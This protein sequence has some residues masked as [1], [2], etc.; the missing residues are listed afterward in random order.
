M[1]ITNNLQAA[2]TQKKYQITNN[3]VAKSQKKLASGLKINQAGDDA[4]G[5]AISEKMRSQIIA[6]N[7]GSQN[8]QDGISLVQTAEG[9]LSQ[10]QSALHRMRELAVQSASDTNTPEARAALNAEFRQLAAEVGD[11]AA[12]TT[13]NSSGV[14]DGTF[15]AATGT[16]L[17][18]QA[19]ANQGDDVAV[20]IEA[21]DSQALGIDS[22]SIA[23]GDD[24]RA[25]ITALDSAIN[26]VSSQ[27]ADLGAT[28]NR[29]E[30]KMSNLD[31]SAENLQAAESRIRDLDMA[32]EMIKFT[33]NKILSQAGN[34]MLA[35]ANTSS[36]SVLNLLR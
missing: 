36:K 8:V 15:S 18:I 34:S 29:L 5:L 28:Q 26:T 25:A 13:F 12:Q 33:T 6:L 32:K 20:S 23:S 2:N 17:E 9:G 16:P 10:T 27:R 24:A 11:V 30:Y 19:G 3:A 4:A 14:L 31:T 22:L 35:Q 7:K 21:M 1:R